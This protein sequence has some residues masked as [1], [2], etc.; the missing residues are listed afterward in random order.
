MKNQN[1]KRKKKPQCI[2][3]EKGDLSKLIK[4]TLEKEN[5]DGNKN[6]F[7]KKKA[8]GNKRKEKYKKSKNNIINSSKEKLKTAFAQGDSMLK[9]LNGCHLSKR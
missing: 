9:K 5:K 6:N 1:Q 4:N 3:N 8:Q 7:R 2:F